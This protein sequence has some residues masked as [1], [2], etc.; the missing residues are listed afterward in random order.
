MPEQPPL[1]DQLANIS[2]VII[3]AVILGVTLLRVFLSKRKEPWAQRIAE[4]S[5][6]VSFVFALGFLLFKPFV[7]QAFYIPSESMENTL[8]KN[9]RILVNKFQYRFQEP[10]RGNVVVFA[11]PPEAT[12]GPEQDYIKRLIGLPGDTVQV[13][14]A[15]IFLDGAEVDAA[16]LGYPGLHF[17]LKT[18]LKLDWKLNSVKLFPD[19]VLIDG[20]RSLSPAELA[21]VLG[22]PSAKVE[23]IPGQTLINGRPL[24]EPYTREDPDYDIVARCDPDEFYMLGDNRNLSADSHEW[25]ALKRQ[26]VIGHAVSVFWPPSRMGAIR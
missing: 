2:P 11:A 9:D 1:T 16:A 22:S 19:H 4:I 23:L 14:R 5:D 8:I 13:K 24:S 3:V 25:G 18:K 21:T 15:R 17:Y 12:G 7:A 26:R 10:H 20:R 6:T